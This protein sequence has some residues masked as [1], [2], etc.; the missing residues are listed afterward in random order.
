MIGGLSYPILKLV[1]FGGDSGTFFEQAA[2][3]GN[4]VIAD[5]R[6]GCFNGVVADEQLLCFIDSI[7][8]KIILW[9]CL[10]D[11]FEYAAELGFIQEK[12][13]AQ[14]FN[15]KLPVVMLGYVIQNLLGKIVTGLA[16]D[17]AHVVQ[18][19]IGFID[20]KQKLCQI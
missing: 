5:F 15:G 20:E 7:G 11:R 1:L 12:M 13:M 14:H 2:E 6:S 9:G 17:R 8:N 18:I 16:H 10:Q 19:Q 4:V 3:I